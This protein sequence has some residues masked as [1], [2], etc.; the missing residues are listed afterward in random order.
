MGDERSTTYKVPGG[1]SVRA[2]L[3]WHGNYTRDTSG[4]AIT[5][6]KSKL[7]QYGLGFDVLPSSG[8]RLDTHVITS[9]TDANG[10]IAPQHYADLKKAADA[11]YTK[12][13]A[14][15]NKARVIVIFCEFKMTA[16]GVTVPGATQSDDSYQKWSYPLCLV[17]GVLAADKLTMLHEMGHGAGLNDYTAEA[18]GKVNFMNDSSESRDVM[19]RFQ[20]EKIAGSFYVQ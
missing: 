2:M 17:G 10:L 15:P 16:R 4:D 20:L 19:Y 8:V 9:A 13:D 1:R 11:A 18:V 7:Q 14:A 12:L 6:A 5:T 3:L